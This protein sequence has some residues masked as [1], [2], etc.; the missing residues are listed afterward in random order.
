MLVLRT[1]AIFV[2]KEFGLVNK[3]AFWTFLAVLFSHGFDSESADAALCKSLDS[4]AFEGFARQLHNYSFG[5]KKGT[6][7]GQ[8]KNPRTVRKKRFLQEQ[9]TGELERVTR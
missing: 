3:Q 4:Q 9:G 2:A 8:S 5:K 7:I 1:A 6:T